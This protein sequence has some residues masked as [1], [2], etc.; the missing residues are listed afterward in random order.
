MIPLEEMTLE[1]VIEEC[2][3]R[4]HFVI[5]SRVQKFGAEAKKSATSAKNG[6]ATLSKSTNFQPGV[7][8]FVS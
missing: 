3:Q 8:G 7:S 2:L 1:V 6:N 5:L 4:S